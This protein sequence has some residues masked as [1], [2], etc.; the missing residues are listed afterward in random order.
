MCFSSNQYF[1]VES[2]AISASNI[3]SFV[4]TGILIKEICS[5]DYSDSKITLISYQGGKE[6]IEKSF[7]DPTFCKNIKIA[8]YNGEPALFF[9][10]GSCYLLKDLYLDSLDG[11]LRT[12]QEIEKGHFQIAPTSSDL[13]K[14]DKKLACQYCIYNDICYHKT[15]DGK[16]YYL[17]IEDHWKKVTKGGKAK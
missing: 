10:D 14:D 3:S 6:N 4:F 16:S 1:Y 12:I 11:L 9:R 7:I 15:K 17:E 8:E 5:A 2:M 13:R